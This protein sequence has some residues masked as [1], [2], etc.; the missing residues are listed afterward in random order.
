MRGKECDQKN[1][2][3]GAQRKE[4]GS[5]YWH[6]GKRAKGKRVKRG[7]MGKKKI[8]VVVFSGHSSVS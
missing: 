5:C 3:D 4:R 1:E 7:T 2:G 8:M 6:E